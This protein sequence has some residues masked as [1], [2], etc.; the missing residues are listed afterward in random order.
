MLTDSI[1][2]ENRELIESIGYGKNGN[3]NI[4]LDIDMDFFT[5]FYCDNT[6]VIDKEN[7]KDIFSEDSLI[8]WIYDKAR[9]ITIAKEPWACGG[10]RNSKRILRLLNKYFL[11]RQNQ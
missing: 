7:F 9:L 2:D 10:A 3:P 11:K 4:A 8:W 5:Y 1:P 6:Y